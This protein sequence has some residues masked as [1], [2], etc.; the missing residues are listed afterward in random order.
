MNG[1]QSTS[2]FNRALA[3][4]PI[5]FPRSTLNQR[6]ESQHTENY[7]TARKEIEEDTNKWKSILAHGLEN[8]AKMTIL[9]TAI[10]RFMHPYQN[11]ND[12]FPQK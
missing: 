1:A 3:Q 2:L 8:V 11:A 4:N 5:P 6:G 9:P 12:I 10:H 7:K